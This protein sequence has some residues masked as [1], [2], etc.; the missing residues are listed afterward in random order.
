MD[1]PR[2]QHPDGTTRASSRRRQRHWPIRRLRGM[3]RL[4]EMWYSPLFFFRIWKL[5]FRIKPSQAKV[6]TES[7]IYSKLSEVRVWPIP[8]CL[9]SLLCEFFL[10][11]YDWLHIPIPIWLQVEGFVGTVRLRIQFIPEPP[12][13][14]NVCRFLLATTCAMLTLF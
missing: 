1:W 5:P 7:R 14:R 4:L 2:N 13:V 11:V 8:T 3:F 10:G 6:T 9:A 12:F